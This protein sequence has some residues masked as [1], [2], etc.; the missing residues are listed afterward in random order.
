MESF[1]FQDTEQDQNLAVA[2]LSSRNGEQKGLTSKLSSDLRR[3]HCASLLGR[4]C[5]YCIVYL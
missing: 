5:V 1:P 4:C 2:P 3:T